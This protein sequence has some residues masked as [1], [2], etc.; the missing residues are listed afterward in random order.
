MGRIFWAPGSGWV[1]YVEDQKPVGSGW[2]FVTRPMAGLNPR[3]KSSPQ[4]NPQPARVTCTACSVV[5]HARDL[6]A[7]YPAEAST[8]TAQADGR[9]EASVSERD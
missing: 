9:F 2:G 4:P 5:S 1:A 3:S 8:S 7:E 6:R